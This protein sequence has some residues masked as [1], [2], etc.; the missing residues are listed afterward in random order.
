MLTCALIQPSTMK[1]CVFY[2]QQ[3]IAQCLHPVLTTLQLQDYE[4]CYAR[5]FFEIATFRLKFGLTFMLIFPV[6]KKNSVKIFIGK[7]AAEKNV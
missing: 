6:T 5:I 3:D 7:S 1:S 2:L 4:E